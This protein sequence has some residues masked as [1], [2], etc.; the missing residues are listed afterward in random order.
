MP[1]GPH[2]NDNWKIPK[3][4]AVSRTEAPRGED[5]HYMRTEGSNKPSRY[6]IRT[7]TIANIP[8]T[9]AMF[10]EEQI[11]DIPIIIAS[12]DPC[13]GCMDRVSFIDERGM[14]RYVS[15]K[16]LRMKKG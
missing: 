5:F 14:S 16:E 11:A 3:G 13:I 15:F 6:K 1:T 2:K 8:P 9:Q 7:P 10:K 12:I 4:E